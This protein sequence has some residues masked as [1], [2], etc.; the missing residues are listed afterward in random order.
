MISRHSSILFCGAAPVDNLNENQNGPQH[1]VDADNV[2]KSRNSTKA[3][4]DRMLPIDL[5]DLDWALTNSPR[6]LTPQFVKHA[7]DF[8]LLDEDKL[9]E[10][11]WLFVPL[12]PV[13]DSTEPN[14]MHETT[15]YLD[16]TSTLLPSAQLVDL[17]ATVAEYHCQRLSNLC[18]KFML[19]PAVKTQLPLH[20]S[21]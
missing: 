10:D 21:Q 17:A 3:S 5:H 11:E 16:S 18:P 19:N 20:P 4:Y 14:P 6:S 9:D 1:P 15:I 7:D 8:D 2:P 12:P 13:A